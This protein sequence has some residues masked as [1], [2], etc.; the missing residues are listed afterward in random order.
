MGL[1]IISIRIQPANFNQSWPNH[2]GYPSGLL[3]VEELD[4]D[5]R[6]LGPGRS[7]D[8]NVSVE[9]DII[10]S[11]GQSVETIKRILRKDLYL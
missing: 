4:C 6:S 5:L 8:V 1:N 11:M 2:P 9:N 3:C 10:V 7:Q